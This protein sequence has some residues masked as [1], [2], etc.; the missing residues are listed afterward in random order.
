MA[1]GEVNKLNAQAR[2]E[3]GKTP[4][5]LAITEMTEIMNYCSVNGVDIGE[6]FKR[7]LEE[8]VAS[9]SPSGS[10]RLFF[11]ASRL[12]YQ[13]SKEHDLIVNILGSDHEFIF[14]R[15]PASKIKCFSHGRE[16]QTVEVEKELVVQWFLQPLRTW[17]LQFYS[18]FL[19][20][21]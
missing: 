12:S 14:I 1:D 18:L 6:E 2:R 7:R 4:K 3:S 13:L 5:Q 19:S 9:L 16:H 21:K 11:Y 20:S 10:I 8:K 15:T 17:G